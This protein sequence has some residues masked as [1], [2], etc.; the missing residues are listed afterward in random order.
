LSVKTR[1]TT[2]RFN[3]QFEGMGSWP[4]ALARASARLIDDRFLAVRRVALF[5][6]VS[7]TR[8]TPLGASFALHAFK[9]AR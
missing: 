6:Q 5:W 8:T 2:E 9:P 4:A 3:Q 7:R 1:T